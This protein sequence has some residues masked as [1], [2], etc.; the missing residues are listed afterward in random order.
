M[1]ILVAF[2]N[3]D[4]YVPEGINVDLRGL[5]IFGH[6]REWGRDFARADA[7]TA[8]A[9]APTVHVRTLGCFG[10][11]DVWRVPHRMQGGYGEILRQMTAQQPQLPG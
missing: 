5:T 10:T 2:G 8:R 11:V 4:V 6:R 9:D 7:P 3:V 1:T